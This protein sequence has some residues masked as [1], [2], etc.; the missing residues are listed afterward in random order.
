M[1]SNDT[2]TQIQR[3][4]AVL[5]D[6]L[7]QSGSTAR[8]CIEITVYLASL[9][10]FPL[11]NKIYYAFFE[12]YCPDGHLPARTTIQAGIYGEARI[13]LQVKAAAVLPSSNM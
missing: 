10:D 3:V 11:M 12:K 4:F 6:I 9:D 13:E 1:I 7:I 5:H 2:A 8:N